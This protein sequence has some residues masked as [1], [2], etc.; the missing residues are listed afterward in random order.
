MAGAL[1]A[2]LV[3]PMVVVNSAADLIAAIQLAYSHGNTRLFRFNA[4]SAWG[5]KIVM[6]TADRLV[7]S[8]YYPVKLAPTGFPDIA[9]WTSGANGA[10]GA[11]F[12]GIEAKW[13]RDRVRPEQQAF[14]DL[15]LAH[16]G[17]AGVARSMEDAG[18]IL[19]I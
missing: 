8:P 19:R 1:G 13:G 9:G 4:G 14:I 17:R 10:S 3:D 18:T 12:V 6:R 15:I 16:G 7:L 2:E 5:G 11:L